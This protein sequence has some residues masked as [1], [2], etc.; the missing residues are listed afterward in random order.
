M[1]ILVYGRAEVV[2]WKTN[3]VYNI[4]LDTALEEFKNQVEGCYTCA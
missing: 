1:L 4:D 3:P 2:Y